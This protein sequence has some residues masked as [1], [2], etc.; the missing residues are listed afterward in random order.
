MEDQ[1]RMHSFC[2]NSVLLIL[3]LSATICQ[4]QENK[5]ISRIHLSD[6]FLQTG[7]SGSINQSESINSM[8]VL[9]PKS[10][11]LQSFTGANSSTND[12][13]YG[14]TVFSSIQLGLSFR[15][16]AKSDYKTNPL[17]RIGI[18]Y[19]S[20]NSVSARSNA[21]NRQPFDTLTSSQTNQSIYVDSMTGRNYSIE[22]TSEQIRLDA[23]LLFRSNQAARWSVMAGIGASYGISVNANTRVSYS[24]YGRE[25]FIYSNGDIRKFEKEREFRSETF[26]NKMNSGYSFYVP[27]GVD[28]RIGKNREFW[29]HA[30][31]FYE[32]RPG[33]DIN[34]I[35]ELRTYRSMNIQQGIGLRVAL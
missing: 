15:N 13:I 33:I 17:L 31:L 3:I 23:S 25:E 22:Y 26:N 24:K 20:N 9:A 21:E 2:R 11:I 8:N 30:H 32:L 14:A 12:F 4:A 34:V 19:V 6:I 18:M 27:M 29:K 28:F 5:P 35:P 1:K 7:L 10:E 16:K